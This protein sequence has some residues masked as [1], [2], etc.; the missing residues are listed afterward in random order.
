MPTTAPNLSLL[1][2][3]APPVRKVSRNQSKPRR[4]YAGCPPWLVM[5]RKKN[6]GA[7]VRDAGLR[8]GAFSIVVLL[9]VAMLMVGWQRQV[10]KR[11]NERALTWVDIQP[12]ARQPPAESFREP[13]TPARTPARSI[14]RA[15]APAS[16]PISAPPVDWHASMEAAAGAAADEIIRQGQYRA[17]GPVERAAAEASRG[18]SIFETPRRQAGD[19]DHDPMQG[20]TLVWHSEH[21]YTELKFPTLKDPNVLVGA[22]NP[23]KCMEPLGKRTPRGDLFD[24][25]NR[26]EH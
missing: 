3:R 18:T 25:M 2:E 12:P 11:T 26:E 7:S 24:D 15:A 10:L 4:S 16:A 9:H 19:I 21:C 5:V 13:P 20:R 8:A 23:P 14:E 6:G 1:R 17:L 22:P